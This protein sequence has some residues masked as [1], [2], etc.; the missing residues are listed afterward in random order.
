MSLS[1]TCM[2]RTRCAFLNRSLAVQCCLSSRLQPPSIVVLRRSG[3]LRYLRNCP[4]V[5]NAMPSSLQPACGLGAI[6]GAEKVYLRTSLTTSSLTITAWDDCR[7]AATCALWQCEGWTPHLLDT[8]DGCISGLQQVA[9]GCSS[10]ALLPLRGAA[11]S[12]AG[13]PGDDALAALAQGAPE[14]APQQ[15]QLIH[16]SLLPGCNISAPCRIIL[17]GLRAQ[18]TVSLSTAHARALLVPFCMDLIAARGRQGCAAHRKSRFD[19]AQSTSIWL[20]KFRGV[21]LHAKRK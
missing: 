19:A 1:R 8:M 4:D 3:R 5:L 15:L 10:R 21:Q 14:G 17:E 12:C 9:D 2:R 16:H 7:A 6:C 18:S 11:V 20:C 13:Q